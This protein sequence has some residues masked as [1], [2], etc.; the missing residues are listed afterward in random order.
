MTTQSNQAATIR[1]GLLVNVHSTVKGGVAYQ[2]VDLDAD[3]V[4]VAEGVDVARWETVRTIEDKDE[5]ERATKARG[6]AL[7]LIRKECQATSFGLLCPE[8]HEGA[9]DAAIVKAREIVDAHNA[10]AVHTHVQVYALKG[11]VASNDAEAARAI[12]SEIAMLVQTMDAGISALDA[13]AIR[14]A[15]DR[16]RVLSAMLDESIKTKVDGAVAQAR[17]AARDITRRLVKNGEEKAVVLADI[18]RGQIESARIA[19]L[20]MSEQT[21]SGEALPSVEPQRFA[22]LD[23][24]LSDAAVDVEPETINPR[25]LNASSANVPAMELS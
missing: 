12:T 9:L 10:T 25:K 14:K 19:F 5:Y 11:R 23:F 21:A 2:R 22:D 24:D 6:K 18:Q 16:A 4:P 13:D 15:A 20:D 17:K 7:A 1:P 8:D 3:G